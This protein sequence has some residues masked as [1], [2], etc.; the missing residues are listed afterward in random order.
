[1][2]NKI[3]VRNTI[4]KTDD[5]LFKKGFKML[6]DRGLLFFIKKTYL[7]ITLILKRIF[8]EYIPLKVMFIFS[9]GGKVI[10]DIQGS[11][12]I[13]D[14]NDIGISRE[15]AIYG[16]HEKNSTREVKNIITKGMNILEV[17]ANIGYY[18]LLETSLAGETGHL[19]A[20]EP[21]PYN[22]DLLTKN[23]EL[24]GLKNY[25]LYKLAAGS[26]EG[27]A[28]FLLSGRSN[29]S[30]FIE[31]EDLTGEEVDVDV[32]KLDNFLVG[33]KV[34]FIRMDVE[35]YELEILKGAEISLSTGKKPKYFFIEVH[36]ELLHKKN[37]SAKEVVEFLGKYGYDIHKS[38]WRGNSKFVA[39]S[40]KE[41]LEHPLLEVGYWETFF[42]L[43]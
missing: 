4:L 20:M 27:K 40:K 10:R 16:V 22:F 5:N 33:K 6:R 29:L 28:K 31:R 7:S 21:S 12:M 8:V 13:L 38:F 18:A 1:M 39:S 14:L 35:G 9:K 24:N 2:E 15:L 3:T 30:T 32:V 25:D 37:S 34:D 41:M 11:K 36:S 42:E 17:G 19:Y 23:L 43:K 26:Q